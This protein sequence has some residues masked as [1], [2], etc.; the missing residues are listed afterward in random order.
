MSPPLLQVPLDAHPGARQDR[1]E[2]RPDGSLEVW[3]RARPVEGQANE[4]VER[5]LAESLGLRPWQVR[6]VAGLTGRHKRAEISL[7]SLEEVRQRIERASS[8]GRRGTR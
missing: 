5:L 6:L 8:R 4:A 7:E 1:I 3:V 2:W